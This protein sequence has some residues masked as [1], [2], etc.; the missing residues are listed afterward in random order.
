[1]RPVRPVDF[2]LGTRGR[3][4]PKVQARVMAGQIAAARLAFLHLTPPAGRDLH[5]RPEGVGV[6]FAD[7]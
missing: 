4:Q 5:P 7:Q 2:H 6:T 3:A 1:M